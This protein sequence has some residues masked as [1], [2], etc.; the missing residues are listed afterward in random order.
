MLHFL[1]VFFML[2]TFTLIGTKKN[3]QINLVPLI[4]GSMLLRLLL[5]HEFQN[6]FHYDMVSYRLV[7]EAT[8]RG[9]NIYPYDAYKY[10]PYLP[11]LLYIEALASQ[12]FQW[13]IHYMVTM[14]VFFSLFDVLN[15]FLIYLLSNK[16][17]TITFLYAVHPG[18][19]FLSAVHGQIDAIPIFFILSSLYFFERR[20]E[21]I[22]SFLLGI[23]VLV[24]TWPIILSLLFLKY[25]KKKRLLLFIIAPSIGFI[26]LYA[27]LFQASIKDILH[28]TLS[29]RGAYGSWGF[30][31]LTALFIQAPERIT[32]LT[33]KI[34]T[35]LTIGLLFFYF[36][37]RKI[38]TL[39]KDMF[40]FLLIFSIVSISG[41]N[42][43]WLLPFVLLLRPKWWKSWI[44]ILGIYQGIGNFLEIIHPFNFSQAYYLANFNILLAFFLWGMQIRMVL[45]PKYE[46]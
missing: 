30:G 22:S 25:L 9:I 23:G 46:T 7:G 3:V 39:R 32:L 33:S 1:L 42:P 16:N 29:Y 8:L 28:P 40:L 14:K 13:G 2:I 43:L 27:F 41:A 19:L 26:L 21:N 44:I 45:S 35:N 10:H 4:L 37:F 20:K 6:V 15:I 11:F 31:L 12:L 34:I 24:K 36:I 17:K 5:I 18:F 38:T